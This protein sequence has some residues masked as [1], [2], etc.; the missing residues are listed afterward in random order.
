MVKNPPY[1]AGDVSSIPAQ[2]TKTLLE[3]VSGSVVSDSFRP[4]G[5]YPA[6]LLCLWNSPG[7]KNTGV[8]SHFLFQ[9]IF[10]TQGS[11]PGLLHCRQ[12]L[13]HL[14]H[15]IAKPITQLLSL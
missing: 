7:K 3:S 9:R 8:G 15:R 4:H 5:L 1:N 2:V 10:P 11:N 12:I 14:S 6:R 13:Y